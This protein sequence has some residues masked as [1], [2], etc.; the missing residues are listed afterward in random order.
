MR[1]YIWPSSL[2]LCFDETW[3]RD[4]ILGMIVRFL[5]ENER[6]EYVLIKEEIRVDLEYFSACIQLLCFRLP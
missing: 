6:C 3:K 1:N 5:S 4:G 2:M